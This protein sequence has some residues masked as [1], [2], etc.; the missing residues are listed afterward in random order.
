MGY[1]SCASAVDPFSLIGQDQAAVYTALNT[2]LALDPQVI[3]YTGLLMA[4]EFADP[5]SIVEQTAEC[6]PAV[7]TV[8]S[9][10]ITFSDY[11]AYDINDSQVSLPYWEYDMYDTLN[12]NGSNYYFFHVDC[13]NDLWLYYRDVDGDYLPLATSFYAYKTLEKTAAGN[14]SICKQVIRGKISFIGDPI[15][16]GVKPLVNLNDATGLLADLK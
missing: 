13:N 8:G 3:G 12:K 10:D 1:I 14:N 6:L 15:N 11:N 7:E 2:M 4:T 9:R 16:M 5:Q